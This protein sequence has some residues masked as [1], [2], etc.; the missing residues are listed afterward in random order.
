MKTIHFAPLQGY[1]TYIYRQVHARYAGGVDAYYTP[2]IRWEKG[3]V[4][5]KDIND[6][7]PEHN[8]NICLIP[9]II[10]SDTDELKRLTDIVASYGYKQININLGCPAPMQTKLMRGSGMLPHPDKLESLLKEVENYKQDVNFS[11]KM[12][13]GFEN[14]DEWRQLTDLLN[15]SCVNQIIMHPR[16]GKQMYKGEVD[17]DAFQEF[18][19]LCT[20]PLFYNGDIVSLD[21]LRTIEEKYPKLSGIMLGRALLGQPFLATEYKNGVINDEE[22]RRI[23]L[24]MHDDLFAY[25]VDKYK[26][27]SQVL[28][29]IHA[30]WEYME[31]YM[32]RKQ[33]KKLMKAGSMKNY[34]EALKQI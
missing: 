29:H 6:I 19:E 5:N 13:L 33:W 27:D 16:V 15:E 14:N 17:M 31:P 8:E 32:I 7:L 12:R 25:C 24:D 34:K 20:K 30:F 2:F 11:V 26:A 10:C 18:Y 23:I 22:R 3:Q 28:L 4:R 21:Q 9:Q 1:T